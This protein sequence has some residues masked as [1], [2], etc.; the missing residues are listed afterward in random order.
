MFQ[1]FKRVLLFTLPILMI[2]ISTAS[3]VNL[4]VLNDN[5][6]KLDSLPISELKTMPFEQF[7]NNLGFVNSNMIVIKKHGF[8][9]FR[10]DGKN[11]HT[12]KLIN[13]YGKYCEAND[14]KLLSLGNKAGN[15][16]GFYPINDSRA[17]DR[18]N[19]CIQK[20]KVLFSTK[21]E[22]WMKKCHLM[23][24]YI[25]WDFDR[26]EFV[27]DNNIST[28]TELEI[29]NI[30]FL[31]KQEELKKEALEINQKIKER[32]EQE[33]E[34]KNKIINELKKRKD[35]LKARKGNIVMD[36]YTDFNGP[37]VCETS[38]KSLNNI[39]NGYYTI[40]EAVEGGWIVAQ[41]LADTSEVTS[42]KIDDYGVPRLGSGCNCYGKKYFM[43]K[44]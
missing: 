4:D 15:F 26:S 34:E 23:C 38:C 33:N 5:Y 29:Q 12:D 41:V 1:N 9:N 22:Q 25:G 3:E 2:D 39:H 21:Y 6:S 43:Q 27:L 30:N 37:K 20:N 24:D 10:V 13:L 8:K 19:V 11:F 17:D 31:K 42:Y 14:G 35:I 18:Y 28:N 7:K 16:N 36:F 44:K 32:Q 40:E